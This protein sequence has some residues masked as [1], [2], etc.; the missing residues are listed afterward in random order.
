MFEVNELPLLACF[1]VLYSWRSALPGDSVIATGRSFTN[2]FC[3]DDDLR[4]GEDLH[5]ANLD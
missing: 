2:R 4:C 3:L 1:F 5:K